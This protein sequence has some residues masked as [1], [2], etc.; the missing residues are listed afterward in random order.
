M[1]TCQHDH[2]GVVVS[3]ND[4]HCP[5]RREPDT[6]SAD[7]AGS[8]N[9]ALYRSQREIEKSNQ[10]FERLFDTQP[11]PLLVLNERGIVLASNR[12][13][14]DLF[15]LT[16]EQFSGRSFADLVAP[17]HQ[18]LLAELLAVLP[19]QA[20]AET[21]LVEVTLA[22]GSPEGLHCKLGLARQPALETGFGAA[23][24]YE[25]IVHIVDITQQRE[26]TR[27]LVA[28]ARRAAMG[29]MLGNITHQWKQPLDA[30]GL[31]LG[32]LED[33]LIHEELGPEGV[34][35][36]VDKARQLM[37]QMN[38]TIQDFVR[39]FHPD[40]AVEQFSA[41][42]MA[43][44]ALDLLSTSLQRYGI[45]CEEDLPDDLPLLTGQP[46][47]LMQVVMILLQN[48]EEA[49]RARAPAEP[50][51]AVR[52]WVEDQQ[53]LLAVS[54]NAGGVDETVQQQ[55]FEPYFSTKQEG[56]GI[57][58]Y[59]ARLIVESSFGGR[60]GCRNTEHGAEFRLELPIR[61]DP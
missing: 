31:S 42:Q 25:V 2:V 60:I 10:R 17:Q 3:V 36:H 61:R 40:K 53:L 48:A 59:L 47:E 45:A 52:C 21:G 26:A 6:I 49:L 16:G 58:L 43:H 18:A 32:N 20:E 33:A 35:K 5:G 11:S 57:G 28:Q 54:D 27:L 41:A 39:F 46:T 7:G 44:N 9:E 56:S 23:H 4:Q 22:D 8:L 12:S 30:L 24:E 34:G 13:A 37:A 19:G 50:W 1:L 38:Q 14:H 15:G 55:M 29:D 51:L